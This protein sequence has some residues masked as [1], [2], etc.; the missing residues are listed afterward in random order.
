MQKNKYK[1][2]LV[3]DEENIRNMVATMLDT[4]GYQPILAD[5]CTRAQILFTSYLPDLMI[6]DLGLP[7]RD[8]MSLLDFVRQSSLL[9]CSAECCLYYPVF[10]RMEGYYAYPATRL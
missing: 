4:A 8:G 7:D 6:L 1:I 3:E 9:F 2:L 5:S 10:K